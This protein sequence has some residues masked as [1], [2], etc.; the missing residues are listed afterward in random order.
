VERQGAID[1]FDMTLSTRGASRNSKTV[2]IMQRLHEKDLSGHIESKLEFRD[3]WTHLCLPMRFE[4]ERQHMTVLGFR[5]PRT[6]EGELLWP[7]LFPEKMVDTL[8]ANLGEYGSAGQ[9]QQRP[10]PSGGGII[11]TG[12]FKLWPADEPLPDFTFVIQSYDTAFTENTQNDPT[13]CIVFGVFEKDKRRCVMVLDAWN[14]HLPYPEL[15]KRVIDDWSAKYGGRTTRKL[16]DPLH[17]PRSVD[18]VIIE[19]K[20]SGISLIQDLRRANVGAV[21][22]N[23]GKSDKFSRA[24][25]AT[26][27]LE[28]GNCY[29]LESSREP[30]KPISWVRP[31]LKEM[32]LFP[33]GDHDDY[34]DCF[35]Q[36]FVYLRDTT[37]L[38][39]PSAPLDFP[40][41]RDYYRESRE[42]AN[43]YLA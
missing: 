38:S 2:V 6:K 20:G 34:V 24:I 36:A 13:A 17:P 41:D 4:H 10:A 21:A 43:P 26:P 27:I 11:K 7:L 12:H 39:L 19:Q 23:P 31:M 15:R 3:E 37:L 42:T 8:E 28:T 33:A 14:E 1:W 35:S 18:V 32:E 16:A 9:L 25:Q 30:G 22:Y 29:I 5:D 40:E